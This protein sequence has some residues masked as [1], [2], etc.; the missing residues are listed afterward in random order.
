MIYPII[1]EEILDGVSVIKVEF[2]GTERPYSSYG[3]YFKRSFDRTEE[4]TPDEL[5]HMML[6][7]DYSSIW[8][9]NVTNFTIDDIDKKALLNFYKKAVSCG[10][11][12]P[13]EEYDEKELLTMLGLMIDDKLTNAGYFLFSNKEP[14]VLKM[15]V[16][17]TDKR[18]N[19]IDINRVYGNIYNLIDIALAYINE[20]MNW[21]VSIDGKDASREEIPEVPTDAIR[22]IVVNAFAHANY[23]SITEHEIAIT[24]T[25]I[26]IYNPGEFPLNYKP[27]DFVDSRLSSMPR[28]QKILR[29]LHLSKNVE[30]QGNGIRKALNVCKK[31]DV[32]YSYINNEYGFRFTFYR[33]NDGVVI[34]D[35]STFSMNKTDKK[36]LTILRNNPL[37]TQEELS[38]QIGKSK[39]TVQR[40]IDK[41]KKYGYIVKKGDRIFMGNNEYKTTSAIFALL[42]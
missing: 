27:K 19:F 20:H 35:E 3:R 25:M 10:R 23:R 1:K 7:T 29:A 8:E 40:S 28:N 11:F 2:Q 6:N 13:L 4:M 31:N 18:L 34:K 42:N 38:Q 36:I 12:A 22:E 21:K 16:Y 24:P 9:N 39:R 26:D 30:M 17:A 33:K 15:A 5:K 32:K 37:L 41:L 14:T